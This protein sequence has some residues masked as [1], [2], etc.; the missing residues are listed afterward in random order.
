VVGQESVGGLGVDER[1]VHQPLDRSAL[2][3]GVAEGVPDRQQMR[4]LLVQFVLEPAKRSSTLDGP[5]QPAAGPVVAD[6][7]GEVGHVPVPHE[8]G[9][10]ID[11]DEIQ[12]VEVDRV[13]AVDAGIGC[14]DYDLT[15]SAG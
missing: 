15:G 5:G 2:G 12:L 4:V 11:A 8:R 3:S 9:Q 7:R 14:P 1:V 6:S 13:V 10:W